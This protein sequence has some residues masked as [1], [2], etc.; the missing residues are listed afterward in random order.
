MA[1]L[2]DSL[3]GSWI[4]AAALVGCAAFE[5]NLLDSSFS[6]P[7]WMMARTMLER[8][9]FHGSPLIQGPEAHPGG[10]GQ[11]LTSCRGPYARLASM[12]RARGSPFCRGPYA[13]LA[14]IL[15]AGGSPWWRGPEALL[16]V[17]GPYVRR[18]SVMPGPSK[19]LAQTKK[20]KIMARFLLRNYSRG[21]G[22]LAH[23]TIE[24]GGC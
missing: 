24:E 1:C 15:G 9:V 4:E 7:R 13:R 14:S 22:A 6:V 12:E 3:L 20:A 23:P 5:T 21:Q 19:R 11:R 16:S 2:Y 10:E 8:A 18:A 17:R